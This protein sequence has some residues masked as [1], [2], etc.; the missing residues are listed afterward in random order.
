DRHL[1]APLRFKRRD[2]HDDAAP[3]VSAFPNTNC[4]HIARNRENLHRL[5]E[6]EAVWRDNDM[7]F[8]G[9]ARIDGDKQVIREGLRIDHRLLPRAGDIGEDLEDRPDAH[10]VSVRGDAVAD[11]PGTLHILFERLN[12]DQFADL[13]IT[14]DAH[15]ALPKT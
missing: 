5:A 11:P 10:I 2:V 1:P 15:D 12:A 7:I 9:I 14:Q 13:T 3:R 8:A 4:Q 6:C